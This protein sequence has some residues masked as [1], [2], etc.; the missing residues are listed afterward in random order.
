MEQRLTT[1]LIRKVILVRDD[2]DP[3]IASPLHRFDQQSG[4]MSHKHTGILKW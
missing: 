1:S 2:Y 3:T 4:S